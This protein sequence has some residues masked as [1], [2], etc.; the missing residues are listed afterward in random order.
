MDGGLAPPVV[1]ANDRFWRRHLG[2][3]PAALGHTIDLDGHATTVVG[4]LPAIV[5]LTTSMFQQATDLVAPLATDQPWF[6]RGTHRS[7]RDRVGA[8]RSRHD[9]KRRERGPNSVQG[10]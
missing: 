4:V 3:D 10:L 1:V 5:E 7:D 9:A 2:A 8:R 6:S